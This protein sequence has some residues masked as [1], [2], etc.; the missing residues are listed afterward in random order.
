MGGWCSVHAAA[1]DGCAALCLTRQV[2]IGSPEKMEPITKVSHIPSSRWA[3]VCSLCNDKFG[4]SIQ[5]ITWSAFPHCRE[6]EE[7]VCGEGTRIQEVRP[8]AGSLSRVP[9]GGL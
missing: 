6:W 2:S 5:V 9:E 1:T 4:A 3:L 7:A 8:G